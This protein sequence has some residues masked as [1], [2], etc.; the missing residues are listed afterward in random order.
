MKPNKPFF[1]MGCCALMLALGGC[2]ASDREKA[3]ATERERLEL[4]QQQEREIRDTNKAITKMN[5]KLGRKPPALDL[6]L[7]AT[8]TQTTPAPAPAKTDQP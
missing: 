8:A 6:G 7:P 5:Q 1:W 2:G 4:E 3:A